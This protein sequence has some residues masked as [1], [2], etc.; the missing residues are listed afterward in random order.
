M[1]SFFYLLSLVLSFLSFTYVLLQVWWW[2]NPGLIQISW[3]PEWFLGMNLSPPTP[4]QRLAAPGHSPHERSFV[5]MVMASCLRMLRVI[6]CFVFSFFSFS[7][8]FW[9]CTATHDHLRWNPLGGSTR[10]PTCKIQTPPQ[11]SERIYRP[12]TTVSNL[13]AR[14]TQPLMSGT[15]KGTSGLSNVTLLHKTSPPVTT[16]GD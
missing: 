4:E 5:A 14:R 2:S 10:S 13:C 16:N 7:S 9:I 8:C 3:D 1:S 11:A 12:G 6:S 15:P